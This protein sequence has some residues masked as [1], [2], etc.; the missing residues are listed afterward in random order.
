VLRFVSARIE[1][2]QKKLLAAGKIAKQYLVFC[3]KNQK[4]IVN[5]FASD[6]YKEMC[7]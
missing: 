7:M 2:T 3:E 4:N 6:K 1:I 5:T